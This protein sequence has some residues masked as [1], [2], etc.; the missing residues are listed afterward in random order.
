MK[1][2]IF[3]EAFLAKEAMQEPQS[4]VEEKENF[5][6]YFHIPIANTEQF[7]MPVPQAQLIYPS[8]IENTSQDKAT[9]FHAKSKDRFRL[10]KIK[11][12]LRRRKD[13]ITD[14]GFNFLG[15]SFSKR[16]SVSALNQ[17]RKGKQSQN[18]KCIFSLRTDRSIFTLNVSELFERPSIAGW[19]FQHW[20]WHAPFYT[21]SSAVYCK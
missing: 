8:S 4:N 1:A 7:Y 6:I 13:H 10:I 5:W 9:I 19:V 20:N 3:L 12:S 21:S 2:S 15:G 11:R 14:K 17:F 16:G 18:L